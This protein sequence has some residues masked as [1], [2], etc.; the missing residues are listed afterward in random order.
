[1]LIEREPR[2]VAVARRLTRQLS[3][4]DGSPPSSIG[5]A[6]PCGPPDRAPRREAHIRTI[7]VDTMPWYDCG[8]DLV[9]APERDT[10]A[11][12]RRVSL[13]AVRGPYALPDAVRRA[14]ALRDAAERLRPGA[15]G[16][17]GR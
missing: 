11:R 5:G 3:L 1:M 10:A 4:L 9:C 17:G 16:R 13:D 15:Q 14:R 12:I 2:F 7:V 6:G 8:F